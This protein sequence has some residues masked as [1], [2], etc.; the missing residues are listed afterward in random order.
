MNTLMPDVPSEGYHGAPNRPMEPL[1]PFPPSPL[2]PLVP[3]AQE[4]RARA[5]WRPPEIRRYG[6]LRHLVRGGSG[7]VGD[8][9]PG[10]IGK[11]KM[12]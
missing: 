4:P 1:V 7:T 12:T 9:A 5:A 6:S 3:E 11:R 8:P 10:F 2:S